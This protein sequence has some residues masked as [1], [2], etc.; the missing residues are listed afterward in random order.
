VRERGG[1]SFAQDPG[2]A[3]FNGMPAAAIA[4]GQVARV[5]PL[6]IL[7]QALA[8]AVQNGRSHLTD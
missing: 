8:D 1:A 4:T 3:E 5:L 6:S 7:A 2:S